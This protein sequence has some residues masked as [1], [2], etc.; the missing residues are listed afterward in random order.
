MGT[1]DI[2]LYG[3][4][5][6]TTSYL[7]HGEY[8]E[9]DSYGEIAA[10]YHLI[11]GE[12]GCGAVVLSSLG[13]SVKLDG[14]HLGT[15]TYPGISKY[16]SDAKVDFSS[17]TYDEG[18]EGLQ[19]MVLIGG[20]TRTCFG[21]FGSYFNAPVKKWNV[22]KKEDIA[23]CKAAGIDPFFG[24]ESIL[25]A[26]YC[27]ELG[28]PYVT[29]DCKYDSELHQKCA[30]NVVSNE[31]IRSNYPNEDI[32]A[33][34]EKYTSQT[35]GLVI[36]T[37]GAKPLLYGRRG[38]TVGS[39][40]PYSVQVVSTLGAGDTFRAGVVYGVWKGLDD[41]A[42]VSFASA[43]AGV[44]CTSFPIALNPPTLEK[45]AALQSQR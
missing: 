14:N 13:C 16:F 11:G 6:I 8:P 19:D 1:S 29:I 27:S 26:R 3:M 38:Q 24:E 34:F 12:T 9:A 33:L 23:T 42:L 31:F 5:L 28:K 2:Y 10:S 25:A 30:V 40:T 21:R 20:H 15:T 17:M 39:F 41:T 35:N 45:I 4:T 36:F 22:P 7:L 37:F 43:T 18:Y 44:A 32:S